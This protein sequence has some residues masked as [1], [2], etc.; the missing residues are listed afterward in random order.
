MRFDP[1]RVR[2][3]GPL[4][5]HAIV[6]GEQLLQAGYPPE[7]AVR[8][9]QLLAQLSRWMEARGLGEAHQRLGNW[10]AAALYFQIAQHIRPQDLVRRS[11]DG[12]RARIEIEAKNDARRPIVSDNLDQDRLVRPKVSAR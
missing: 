3:S 7:R 12:V 11:L 10:R 5:T 8:H 2:V 4:A 6:F 1:S 9:V